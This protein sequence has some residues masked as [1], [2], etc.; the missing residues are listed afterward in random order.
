MLYQV[1]TTTIGRVCFERADVVVGPVEDALCLCIGGAR[2]RFLVDLRPDDALVAEPIASVKV[3]P[4]RSDHG[5]RATSGEREELTPPLNK[6]RGECHV[7]VH[8]HLSKD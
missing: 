6:T 2:Q 4:E 1:M 8:V 5:Q 3:S 7:A